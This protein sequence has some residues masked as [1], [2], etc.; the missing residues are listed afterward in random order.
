VTGEAVAAY[1]RS[2]P[3]P[4][5]VVVFTDDA[6]VTDSF[7]LAVT[8]PGIP[9]HSALIASAR[10][11]SHE[12][13]SEPELAYRLSPERWIAVTGTNGKTTTTELTAHVLNGCGM[14]ARVAGN[15]GT[16]CIE[17][18]QTREPDEYLVVELSSYQLAYSNTIAP[19]VAILLNIT[20][21]HLSWHGTF[22]AYRAEKVGLLDRVDAT[23]PVVIDATLSETRAVVRARVAANRRVIPLGTTDG[24]YS[25]MTVR[26]G[27]REAAFVDPKT[28][29]LTCVINGHRMALAQTSQLELKGEHNQENALAGA[30]V[31]LALG[32]EPEK[33]TAALVGFKPLEHRIEPCGSV[34]DIAFFNDSKATNPEA[35]C[36]ALVAFENTPLLIMLG[37]RD[38]NTPLDELVRAVEANCTVAVCYGEAGPRIAAALEAFE[39]DNSPAR[40]DSL[41]RTTPPAR[42]TSP[43]QDRPLATFLVNDFRSAFDTAV[44]HAKAN[45]TVLLSPACSSFDEFSSYE[46]RGN[47]FKAL[48]AALRES[49]SATEPATEPAG[50][51]AA[52]PAAEPVAEP[53]AKPA[54]TGASKSTG[55]GGHDGD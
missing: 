7:D 25:D 30:A 10:E 41:E 22:E 42:T 27:S 31:A 14:K 50:T 39:C 8:S 12:L 35:S 48:V 52:E 1:F 32:A 26:C 54:G 36:R 46:Q 19:D 40:G 51:G 23:A 16:T 33:V 18:I 43:R 34:N 21:D 2:L 47:L 20:P 15:I 24:L 44:A 28:Q 29:E 9:P 6:E 5:A 13:I 53:A 55:K 38:K 45:D 11:H 4:P 3:N 49:A 37:G 17:A